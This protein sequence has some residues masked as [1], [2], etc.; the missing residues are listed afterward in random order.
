MT[1]ARFAGSAAATPAFDPNDT[2]AIRARLAAFL[3]AEVGAGV[4]VGPLHRFTVGFSWVTYGFTATRPGAKP[5]RLILRIGPPNGILAPYSARP[6]ALAL[7]SLAGSGVPVAGVHAF[8]D[9]LSILGAPFYV[10]D[11]MPGEAPVPWTAD[12]G[13]AFDEATRADMGEQ[14][15]AALA[16]LHRFDWS[17]APVAALEGERDPARIV[18]ARIDHWQERAHGWSARRHPMLEWAATR[19]RRTAPAARGVC[20]THG[21][22]RIGNFLADKGRISAILDWEL[23]TL[24]DPLEDLGWVCLQAWRGRS[25]YMCHLLDRQTLLARYAALT[26]APV[27]EAALRWWEAFGTYKLAVMHLAAAHCF[28]FRGFN[29]LRMAGMGAQLPR[30]LL[31][32]EAAVERAA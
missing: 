26:G 4:D 29:D 19:L 27:D 15:V 31:Q 16:A 20:L 5:E 8:S 22:Y 14:F 23:V 13:P 24:S 7:I 18:A 30:M 21:D 2:G 11:H 10:C 9:D 12:G 25:P 32:V 3:E 1:G 17:N 28:E 6:E